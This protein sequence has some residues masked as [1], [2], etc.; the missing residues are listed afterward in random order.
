[1]EVSRSLFG[2]RLQHS[3]RVHACRAKLL[4]SWVRIPPGVGLFHIFSITS[5]VCPSDFPIKISLAVQLE[6]KQA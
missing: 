1:M 6:A 4:R 5:I 2:L 3:G